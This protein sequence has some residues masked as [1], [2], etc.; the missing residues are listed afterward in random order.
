MERKNKDGEVF[1]HSWNCGEEGES[2]DVEVL[3][4]RDQ[5]RRNFLVTLLLSQG[6]PMLTAGDEIGRT[7]QGNNNAFC[8]DNEISW[9]DWSLRSQNAQLLQFTRDLIDLRR[10]HPIFRRRKWFE[11]LEI[12]NSG[13]SDIG[14][15]NPDGFMTGEK[16]WSLGFAKA[17]ALF[18]NGREMSMTNNQGKKIVDH[19][20]M[21]FFNAHYEAIKF[22]IP[23]MLS[24]QDWVTV[25]DTTRPV[26][27]NA[28][29]GGARYRDDMLIQVDARSIV[30]LKT[31]LK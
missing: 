19:S 25:I 17:I 3:R 21:L 23:G 1:N 16:E 11:G 10:H 4:L 14:W 9:L 15:F 29:A 6:V 7:Q 30:V 13:V 18:L 22:V 5:Q 28:G 12:N 31:V 26:L 27:L 2:E 24:R 8:Q 20:F